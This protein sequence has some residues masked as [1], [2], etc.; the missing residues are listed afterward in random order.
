VL[1]PPIRRTRAGDYRVELDESVRHL[2]AQL[3]TELE[4]LL[5]TDSPLLARLFPPPYGDDLERNEGYAALAV[6]ELIDRRR[7]SLSVLRA[8]V[9]ATRL[10][11]EELDAWMRSVNDLRLVLGT[12][13]GLEDDSVEPDVP[14]DLLDTLAAY[15]FLGGLLDLIVEALSA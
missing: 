14:D 10:S 13:L 1:R 11:G 9:E 8:S 12:L 15:E 5:D 2:L 6:P 7:A 4:A 3:C